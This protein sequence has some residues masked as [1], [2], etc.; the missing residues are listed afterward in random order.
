M[1]QPAD[2]QSLERGVRQLLADKVS[3]TCLGLW[4][5]VPEH[6]RL[7]TWDLLCGWSGQSADR[8]EPRLALQ[9]VHEAALC[10]T[11]MREKRCFTQKTFELANGL[12]FLASDK[13]I[14]DLLATHTV[15]EAQELQI[16]LGKVR[17]ASGHF[18]GKLL[19]VD[20]HRVRSFSQRHMRRHRKD[21]ASRP[22][23]T[24]QTFFLL[25]V[26]SEQPV[27]FLTG[28][29]ARTVAQVTPELLTLGAD[30]LNPT[31]QPTV[32]AD[33]E[34]FSA[35]LLDQVRR[36][37]RF[38]LLVPMPR[39][40]CLVERLR[41]I[42]PDQFTPRWAG[43]ATMRRPYELTHSQTGPFFQF[44]Q[45]LGERPDDWQ[46]N[47]F[48]STSNR[49]EVD[50]LTRD[51]PQRWHL[52]E[53]FNNNQHLGWKRAGT[54]NLNIRYGQMTMALMAQ[55]AICQ[56]RRRLGEPE[57][58]WNAAHLSHSLLQSL[59]GDLRVTEDTIVVTY[60]NA[61]NADRLRQHYENLPRKLASE[62]VQAQVPWLYQ[63]KL[64]FRFR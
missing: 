52:E 21:E 3:G 58:T 55:A 31:D 1:P 39:Q 24:A 17:R 2:P 51:Y 45:R 47:A 59:D 63:Y 25:D 28:T 42:P 56:L 34:H 7:G 16:A 13:A 20:P 14:H 40:R 49:D 53:F 37:Q 62:Q 60:Y 6:L 23:K 15:A 9:L 33:C 18:T 27:A 26:E 22:V 4:L 8:V 10:L 61:P 11:G 64:D 50:P 36:D 54:Q 44:I 48:L 30:I 29:S 32:L 19:A 43:Y 35:E 57:K 46:F 41:A 5:L 38:N 12:P